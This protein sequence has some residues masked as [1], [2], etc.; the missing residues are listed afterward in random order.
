VKPRDETPDEM[1]TAIEFEDANAKPYREP[2]ADVR[3]SIAR[4]ID[5]ARA[6]RDRAGWDIDGLGVPRPVRE[7]S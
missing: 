6:M 7:A 4:Q 5:E 2:M 1:E 3:G